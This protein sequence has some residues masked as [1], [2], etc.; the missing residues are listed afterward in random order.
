MAQSGTITDGILDF[1]A[2]RPKDGVASLAYGS[3]ETAL[4]ASSE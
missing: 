1:A 3:F 4:R 2:P